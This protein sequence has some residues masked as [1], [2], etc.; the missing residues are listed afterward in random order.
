VERTKQRREV[1]RDRYGRGDSWCSL[2]PTGFGASKM[3]PINYTA[4]E[5]ARSWQDAIDY[6]ER[7]VILEG[8]LPHR[9][10]LEFAQRIVT[11]GYAR[12]VPVQISIGVLCFKPRSH[13]EDRTASTMGTLGVVNGGLFE[14]QIRR[15]PSG[16][17]LLKR[18]CEP[19]EVDRVFASVLLRLKLDREPNA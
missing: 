1:I 11:T 7:S 2:S 18:Q 6:F 9:P 4:E 12:D 16:R 19:T 10:L 5:A 17:I 14:F 13:Y 3:T 8:F 15:G